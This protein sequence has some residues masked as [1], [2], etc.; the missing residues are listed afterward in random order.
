[1]MLDL[2]QRFQE[3][4]GVFS[5]TIDEKYS[6]N[7]TCESDE[8]DFL[9]PLPCFDIQLALRQ[10]G[11]G[12]AISVIEQANQILR[13]WADEHNT[14]CDRS[15]QELSKTWIEPTVIGDQLWAYPN[16]QAVMRI[17]VDLG[18]LCRWEIVQPFYVQEVEVEGYETS[19]HE[20]AVTTYALA[21]KVVLQR[22]V[23]REQVEWFSSGFEGN[24]T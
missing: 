1:M 21:A 8:P 5:A 2:L 14:P 6:G 10:S 24:A 4:P 7:Y 19:G 18:E 9:I 13:V 12:P 23:L 11:A 15:L 22:P 20:R 16:A 3:L 17:P